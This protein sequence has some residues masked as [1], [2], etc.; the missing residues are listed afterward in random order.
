MPQEIQ[1]IDLGMVNCYLVKTDRG[2]ILIDT[3]MA[4]HRPAVEKALVEAGCAEG[5]LKLVILTHGDIDHSGNCAYLQ[6]KYNAKIAMHPGDADMCSSGQ[7]KMDRKITSFF[8]KI[9]MTIMFKLFIGRYLRKNPY[10]IFKPDLL[11]E[12]G[13]YLGDF[14]FDAKVIHVPGH[15][16]GSIV[17]LTPDGKLLCGDILQNRKKPDV[18]FIVENEA[19][20]ASSVE[21]LKK[22]KIEAVYPGHGKMFRMAEFAKN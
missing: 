15:T 1:T 16:K 2:F 13:R 21:K 22:L 4:S 10:E 7:M 9:F 12:D 14:G 19:E 8:H 11:L 18:T 6:R 5:G 20:L 17:V 3:G